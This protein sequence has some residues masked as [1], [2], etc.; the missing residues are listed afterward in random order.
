MKKAICLLFTATAV[1]AA[2]PHISGYGGWSLDDPKFNYDIEKLYLKPMKDAGFNAI[3]MKVFSKGYAPAQMA[4][5][6]KLA[7]VIQRGGLAFHVYAT[8]LSHTSGKYG[9][10]AAVDENGKRTTRIC[11]GDYAAFRKVY[12]GAYKMAA[13]SGKLG[14]KSVKL[15]LEWVGSMLPCYCDACWNRFAVVNGLPATTP[16]AE[17]NSLLLSRNLSERYR[18][19]MLANW[20][21]TAK[22]YE[23]EMHSIAPELMLGMMP[24]DDNPTYLPFVKYLAAGKVPA[25]MDSWCMY[26]G[27]GYNDYTRKTLEWIRAQNPGNIPQPWLWVIYYYPESVASQCYGL[28]RDGIGYTLYPLSS[29]RL[30]GG[31]HFP[32]KLAPEVYFK[33]FGKANHENEERIAKGKAYVEK[34]HF[35]PVKPLVPG[36]NRKLAQ[37]FPLTALMPDAKP[38]RISPITLRHQSV[39]YVEAA[40][41]DPL[42]FSLRH[43]CGDKVTAIA[44]DIIDPETDE[45]LLSD[46]RSSGTT[47][48]IEYPVD[49]KRTLAVILYGG[50][51]GPWYTVMFMNKRF[52]MLGYRSDDRTGTYFMDKIDRDIFLIPKTD[53]AV[54]SFTLSGG[55]VQYELFLPDGVKVSEGRTVLPKH[56]LSVKT[57]VP[58]GTAGKAWR[59][60][61][62]SPEKTVPGEH[63]QNCWLNFT[64]GLEPV[65]GFSPESMLTLKKEK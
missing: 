51:V 10:P 63:I 35:A 3:D 57:V 4:E 5:L 54:F 42:S 27:N 15:D 53:A 30:Q 44:V 17:R 45:V 23:R 59:L 2:E 1:V 49:R 60:H 64:S 29:M 9:L 50:E 39:F 19:A 7:G 33:A 65:F 43:C 13:V 36:C 58:A 62:R 11:L 20:E 26:G 18:D 31:N 40:P 12:E 21:K 52:G 47:G 6:E 38:K 16:P 46:A 37:K 22:S 14:I 55:P 8:P 48:K 61:L 34:I 24:A 41:G 28:L 25:M 56:H 32:G